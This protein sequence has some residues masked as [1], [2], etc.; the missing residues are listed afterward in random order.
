MQSRNWCAAGVFLSLSVSFL[1]GCGS[2]YEARDIEAFL[3]ASH[4]G[5][6]AKNY[7]LMPPDV[8]EIHC[9]RVPELH[10]QSQRIRPDGRISFEGIGAIEAAGKTPS[11]VADVLRKQVSSLYSLTGDYPIDVRVTSYGSGFYHVLGEVSD[12]G[13]KPYTGRDTVLVAINDA[14]PLVTAWEERIRIIRPSQEADVKAKIFEFDL[15]RILET[16][17]NSQDILLRE[18]DIVYV[19]PT[20]A[21]A[22]AQGIAEFVTPIGVALSP[23]VTFQR[24]QSGQGF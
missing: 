14:F 11:E 17:D 22:I 6:T 20:I 8:V 23:A 1:A 2:P 21:A 5:V 24:L 9:S 19:P 4:P 13:P 16:G 10:L 15:R 12:P 3:K 7:I 18:G